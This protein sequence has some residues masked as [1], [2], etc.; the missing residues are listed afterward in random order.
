M[1]NIISTD[2]GTL[3]TSTDLGKFIRDYALNDYALDARQVEDP[4]TFLDVNNRILKPIAKNMLKKRACCTGQLKMGIPLPAID[5]ATFMLESV[6]VDIPIFEKDN[7]INQQTCTLPYRPGENRNYKYTTNDTSYIQSKDDSCTELYEQQLCPSVRNIRDKNYTARFDKLYGPYEDKAIG[8]FKKQNAFKD[9]NCENSF[10]KNLSATEL[11]SLNVSQPQVSTDVMAQT[12]DLRCNLLPL[13][14]WKKTDSRMKNLC[15]NS[16]STGN[17]SAKDQANLSLNQSCSTNS[18]GP[19]AT[20]NASTP[21][22]PPSNMNQSSPPGTTVQGP[23]ILSN[24]PVPPAP[25][26]QA[27]PAPI[28]QAPPAPISQV[29]PAPISQASPSPINPSPINP[30]PINLIPT[31]VSTDSKSSTQ[32]DINSIINLIIANK[33]YAIGIVVVIILIIVLSSKKKKASST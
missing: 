30:S 3:D 19:T 4:T 21:R 12:L 28:S 22:T 13:E 25:I 7:D 24:T 8:S 9:C 5:P 27:P 14:A 31:P 20:V 2:N 26:S 23:P 32:I 29:P 1:G 15:V 11:S 16:I 33:Y 18:G 17:I 10:Y 6:N